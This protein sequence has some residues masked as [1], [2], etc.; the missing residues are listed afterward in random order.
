MQ[1][2]KEVEDTESQLYVCSILL[3]IARHISI[4]AKSYYQAL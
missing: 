4:S 1:I 2:K 3:C